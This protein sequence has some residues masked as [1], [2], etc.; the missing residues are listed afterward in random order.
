[1]SGIAEPA[2]TTS[3]HRPL[4][5]SRLLIPGIA[6]TVVGTLA[7]GL[8]LGLPQPAIFAP[9]A[10][11]LGLG[12]LLVV[13][14]R[15]GLRAASAV[16][17]LIVAAS[18]LTVPA[19]ARA[20]AAGSSVTWTA[21]DTAED[22]AVLDG[23]VYTFTAE[24][25]GD[26]TVHTV[27][28]LDPVSGSTERSWSAE[29]LERPSITADGDVVFVSR[30][31]SATES[32]A[33]V[34]LHSGD[35]G[36]EWEAPV[37]SAVDADIRVT[38]ASAG[39]VDVVA[40][41]R[42]EA[43]SDREGCRLTTIDSTGSVVDERGVGFEWQLDEAT[44]WDD[45]PG[46]I[47]PPA[48]LVT[49]G[50]TGIQMHV[51]GEP[52]PGATI[53]FA[54]TMEDFG[55]QFADDALITAERRGD[56]GCRVVARSFRS[57]EEDWSTDVACTP[58]TDMR[59]WSAGDAAGPLHLSLDEQDERTAS[60]HTLDPESGTLTRVPEAVLPAASAPTNG[61]ASDTFRDATAGRF[62]L[63]GDGGR[64]RVSDREDGTDPA[65]SQLEVEVPGDVTLPAS[66]GGNVLAI[67]SDAGASNEGGSGA[68]A[69]TSDTDEGALPPFLAH[70]PYLLSRW[71]GTPGGDAATSSAAGTPQFL[72]VVDATTGRV[73][74]STVSTS[75]ITGFTVAAAGQ[76]IVTTEDGTVHSVGS[77]E[78]T[79]AYVR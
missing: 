26:R 64:V 19:V 63:S 32:A 4:P 51:P 53:P 67:V 48:T 12:V 28:L 10:F 78:S 25:R 55:S 2:P 7:V 33:V 8:G 14:A 6:L 40:C 31:V 44:S 13:R 22:L 57:G 45:L 75:P 59:L 79:A 72:T 43:G 76:T 46:R 36:K 21:A 61:N 38:A 34:S 74:S 17:G 29:A 23:D 37:S 71:F 30:A 1:M 65:T 5:R 42:T 3:P 15:T 52:G 68:D 56:Q 16:V 35:G 49:D 58:M 60:L 62:V 11:V 18:V 50:R 47:L 27:R 66:A 41:P 54:A 70:N 77:R 24:D 9:G 69:V 39:A 73:L 20:A